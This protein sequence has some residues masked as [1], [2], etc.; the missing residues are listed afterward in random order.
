M[1][2]R[3]ASPPPT[4]A[5]GTLVLQIGR[6]DLLNELPVVAGRTDDRQSG[7]AGEPY[8]PYLPVS[9]ADRRRGRCG[10]GLAALPAAD[11]P[12]PP[13]WPVLS[14]SR[15]SGAILDHMDASNP[16]QVTGRA[17]ATT[18][19]SRSTWTPD[20]EGAISQAPRGGSV[21]DWKAHAESLLSR[22]PCVFVRNTQISALYAALYL[23]RPALF[24]WSGLAAIASRHIRPAL[25]PLR[26]GADPG[27]EI[28]LPRALG[29]WQALRPTDADWIRQTNNGIFDDIFWAH[30]AYDGSEAGLAELSRAVRGTP[31][32][33]ISA[34]FERLDRGGRLAANGDPGGV[35]LIW[36]ANRG[37]L[38]HEQRA[39]VQPNFDRLSCAYARA[40]SFAA[41]AGFEAR[42]LWR[43]TSLLTSFY[44][45]SAP[46]RLRRTAD[47][48]GPP[49]LT[50]FE[51][52]WA[53]I[54][55]AIVPR[56]RRHET[57]G[58]RLHR[59]LMTI[60]DEAEGSLAPPAAA[61]SAEGP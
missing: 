31:H 21:E 10:H 33:H 28:D 9:H 39:L 38:E 55:G 42:G 24:K 7:F 47:G 40:F 15:T 50:C 18:K 34:L 2:D 51:D 5:H 32:E 12:T 57:R 61:G 16:F 26:L 44:L 30:L 11:R 6:H 45:H 23:R 43:V 3:A 58:R 54:D 17:P 14:A 35:E 20:L 60:V 41:T 25:W 19:T 46:R 29:R 27:D 59:T 48:L 4:R 22:Q 36:E 53:W 37:I 13:T 49:L 56:F 8:R 52:R 1:I